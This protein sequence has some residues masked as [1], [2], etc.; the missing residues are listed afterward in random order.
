MAVPP[1][2][3]LFE[4]SACDERVNVVMNS[5]LIVSND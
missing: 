1:R 2:F 3:V 5:D 4:N